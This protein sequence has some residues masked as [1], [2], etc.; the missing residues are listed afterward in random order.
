MKAYSLSRNYFNKI[1]HEDIYGYFENRFRPIIFKYIKKVNG[2]VLDAA[3]GFENKYLKE[4]NYKN[5]VGVD[6]DPDVKYKN[7]LHKNIIIQ[8]L[9]YL[10][11][12][13]KFG[14]IVSVNT[15]EHLHSPELVLKNFHNILNDD[16]IIIII[17]P[18]RWHYISLIERS[19]PK[20]LKNKAWKVLKG[21]DCMPYQAYY[22][23]CSKKTLF[24]VAMR[25][26]FIIEHFSTVEGPPLWFAHIPPLFILMC[27]WMSFVNRYKIFE[28]LRSAFI[29]VMRKR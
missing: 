17:A 16:G 9:H 3:C 20:Y 23:L 11:L 21:I 15:W 6:I 1:Y 4:L 27:A 18:Q 5:T 10:D 26:G 2:I 22:Q 28:N 25:N 29:V 13:Q 7:K 24:S 19:L 12:T 8:D 14:G